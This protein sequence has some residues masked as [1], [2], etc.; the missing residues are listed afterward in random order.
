MLLAPPE[1]LLS[2]TVV[3]GIVQYQIPLDPADIS[4]ASRPVLSDQDF[5]RRW[6]EYS[7][8]KLWYLPEVIKIDRG[9]T[10]YQEGAVRGAMS[11][12]AVQYARTASAMGVI[13]EKE[14]A[15]IQDLWEA[16]KKDP[17]RI[18]RSS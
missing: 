7:A 11:F 12:D 3:D 10:L 9:V 17:E 8:T 15:Q 4:T 2:P 18:V 6:V 1:V 16:T 13:T 5:S 14:S